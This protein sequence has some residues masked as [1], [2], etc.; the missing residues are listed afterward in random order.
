MEL[1]K[2]KGRTAWAT[3]AEVAWRVRETWASHLLR[4]K[5]YYQQTAFKKPPGPPPTLTDAIR[6]EI[7]RSLRV[8]DDDLMDVDDREKW[9]RDSKTR[10]AAEGLYLSPYHL[11]IREEQDN[12]GKRGTKY[13]DPVRC[14]KILKGKDPVEGFAQLYFEK[15][16]AH[17]AAGGAA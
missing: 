14:W 6:D 7:I 9:L 12:G 4:R 15:R 11:G 1:P 16:A 17:E 3:R 2:K 8:H 13:L 10:A 5:R